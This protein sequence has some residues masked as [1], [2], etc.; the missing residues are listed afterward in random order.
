VPS[1]HK[2]MIDSGEIIRTN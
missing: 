1:I 2:P